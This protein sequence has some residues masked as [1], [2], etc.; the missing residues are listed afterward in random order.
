VKAA[1]KKEAA[2][3]KPAT[4]PA[5]PAPVDEDINAKIDNILAGMSL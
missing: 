5:E 3:P 2:A 1:P 4:K